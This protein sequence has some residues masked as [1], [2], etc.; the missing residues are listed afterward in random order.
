M[1]V[2]VLNIDEYSMV[3]MYTD[4]VFEIKNKVKEEYGIERLENFLKLNYKYNQE[5]IIENL[6]LD[7]KEFSSTDNYDDDIMLVMLKN[8]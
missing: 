7:L 4:G 8:K 3:C 1:K 2:T 6:K 5:K